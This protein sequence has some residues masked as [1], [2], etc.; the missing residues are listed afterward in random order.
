[1]IT[2][3]QKELKNLIE[4][5]AIAGRLDELNRLEGY[6]P[7]A[8]ISRRK[9]I[10]KGQLTK[11]TGKTEKR[12]DEQVVNIRIE[13]PT[14]ERQVTRKEKS[15]AVNLKNIL[16]GRFNEVET[17]EDDDALIVMKKLLPVEHQVVLGKIVREL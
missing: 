5:A 1:M 17:E 9:G 4:L 6:V 16:S 2:L 7:S 13:V 12:D 11:L 10:L 15:F 3:S 14:E 8:S